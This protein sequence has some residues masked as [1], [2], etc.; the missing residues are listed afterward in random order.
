LLLED[1][2]A[3]LVLTDS[4]NLVAARKL[5][6]DQVDVIDVD[7]I[8]TDSE[9]Q[10]LGLDIS[11]NDKAYILYT[12]GTTGR[13]KGVVENHRNLLHN[14]K[15]YTNDCFISSED[16]LICL[17][18]TAYSGI[19]KDV[20]G[21][22]LN[23]AALFPLDIQQEGL[24]GLAHWLAL[25]EI[26]VYDSA[27]TVFRHFLNSLSDDAHFPT[28]RFVRLG[29]E[30]V[31]S[32][33]VDGFRHFFA[34]KCV[35]VNGY[36]AT[37]SGTSTIYMVDR[38]TKVEGVVPIGHAPAGMEVVLLDDGC[39]VSGGQTGQ[40][41]I[42]SAYLACG[43][44]RQPE[45]TERVFLPSSEGKRLYLTGDL[46]M[47]LPDGA[48]VC[49]GRKDSQVK[50]RGHRLEL[51]EVELAL[52][53]LPCVK[54]AAVRPHA[55]LP[56]DH[57]LVG[58]I[59]PKANQPIP[60]TT[61]LR[62]LLRAR[63]PEHAVPSAFVFLDEMPRSP[64]GK[65]DPKRLPSPVGR[66]F[67]GRDAS[68][69]PRDEC[70]AELIRMWQEVLGVPSVG[71]RD[72]FFELGGHS[73]LAAQLF[74]MIRKTFNKELSLAS[75]LEQPTVEQLARTICA[76][77]KEKRWS[78]LVAIQPN[79]RQPRFYCVHGIGGEVL[80]FKA[81]AQHLGADQPFFGLQDAK[82]SE[83]EEPLRTIE[84]MAGR[85]LDE[86]L[87]FQ[88]EG[89]YFIG[90]YSSGGVIAYEMA[91]QL[92]RAGREV[93][94][95][96][97][98]DHRRPDLL[99]GLDWNVRTIVNFARNLPHWIRN[100]LL[101]GTPGELAGRLWRK[102]GAAGRRLRAL[103][104]RRAYA[105]KVED[106]F[107]FSRLPSRYVQL[108]QTNFRAVR[109]YV[110]RPY[111]GRLTLFRA[112]GQPLAPG[113]WHE[114]DMGWGSLPAGGVEVHHVPGNHD[115]I[116]MEPH[117]QTLASQLRTSLLKAQRKTRDN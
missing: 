40:I 96:A 50:V 89:P 20:Y 43:Y 26:T 38:D 7:D 110:P 73:L 117:V 97:V 104:T 4:K 99:P 53:C 1:S 85:Y 98:I 71:V 29:G 64:N 69:L 105:P 15:N 77:S 63:L 95:L 27:P 46:G 102:V 81:L 16:R 86:L 72:D 93:A 56:L 28:V 3:A 91:Q 68:A 82:L 65:F 115:R 19:L 61:E 30:P 52:L 80:S 57:C 10:D 14:I 8:D 47:R 76:G 9:A 88:P 39:E 78:P 83:S 12:S 109:T 94:L 25:Q 21:A 58:Y 37:E 17:G 100:D 13:P 22:L 35:M 101:H 6:G 111:P 54:E 23:G 87:A 2:G 113:A 67:R 108:F 84:A 32:K 18:S 55:D 45:L 36:G 75:L 103:C 33:D 51:A 74:V 42:R 90:G 48:F 31:T 5:A 92:H 112:H 114:Y 66:T 79:G 41:G 107:N 49:I 24:S 106:F 44:W 11:P 70:E 59:V 116:L 60:T 62:R 34:D